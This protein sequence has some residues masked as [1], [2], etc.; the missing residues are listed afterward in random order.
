MTTGGTRRAGLSAGSSGTP[1]GATIV[2]PD[3]L[4]C[5]V[6]HIEHLL[7]AAILMDEVKDN[8]SFTGFSMRALMAVFVALAPVG[9]W[10]E[11]RSDQVTARPTYASRGSAVAWATGFAV[12]GVAAMALAQAWRRF[13]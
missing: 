3:A 2:T 5:S 1:R 8:F 4:R 9:R 11:Y 12:A 13:R 6:Q 7:R 10:F